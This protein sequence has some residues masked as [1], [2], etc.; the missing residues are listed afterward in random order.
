M[1]GN[2]PALLKTPEAEGTLGSWRCSGCGKRCKVSP[3]R[4][5]EN[6]NETV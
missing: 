4:V 2:K 1:Q 6:V 5:K 3:N